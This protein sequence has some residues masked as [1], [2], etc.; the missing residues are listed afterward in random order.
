MSKEV[1]VEL[2]IEPAKV[3]VANIERAVYACR[4]CQDNETHTP[5]ITAP[6]PAS[7]FPGSFA[8]ASAVSYIMG[9]KFVEGLPLYR[10]E[11]ALARLGVDV[12]RQ[13]LAN[14]MLKG[15]E[16]LE[17]LYFR[18]HELLLQREIL[19][20]DETTLQVLHEEGRTA[21]KKSYLWLYRTG[22]EGP[23]I[24]LFE[25]QQTREGE[26]PRRFLLGFRGYLHVDCY[27]GYDGLVKS[28][29][30]A[31]G[32]KLPPDVI[33]SGCLAHA[34]RRFDE[35]L[36]ALAP[37]ARKSA[38]VPA[39]AAGLRFCNDL[40]KIERDLHE[41]TPEERLAGRK[42]KSAKVVEEF[43]TWLH[44]RQASKIMPKS[45]TGKAIAYCINNWSKLTEFLNDGRLEIDNNRGERSIK[46]FVMGRK[47]WLFAN[48]PR[49]AKSSAIIYSIVETAK[50]NGL[51]PYAYIEH[52]LLQLPN[53]DTKDVEA[54]DNLLPWSQALP[55]A[56]QT[57]TNPT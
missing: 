53:I 23:H 35:A 36:K 31:D 15:A 37:A 43:K 6:M 11:K 19:H 4:A 2:R 18:L 46:A 34:R 47:A 28:T 38:T 54:L 5:V 39:A 50:E 29:E 14:W 3:Y 26:H 51:N 12:S 21:Q 17:I 16:W 32:I 1:R 55:L 25:Y 52:I 41:A 30:L 27:S 9:Q 10:Q 8:S 22:R 20:A 40:F 44:G 13:T 56:C 49:G 57:P 7:A 42:D 33:L 45:A 24:I 48:T